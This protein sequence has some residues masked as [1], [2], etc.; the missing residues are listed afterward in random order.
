MFLL[1]LYSISLMLLGYRLGIYGAPTPD[2]PNFC[3]VS[4]ATPGDTPPEE[5]ARNKTR[6]TILFANL[7]RRFW[8]YTSNDAN[9]YSVDCNNTR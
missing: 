4:F 2:S 8:V 5:R 3:R 6:N 7:C 9:A 1:L